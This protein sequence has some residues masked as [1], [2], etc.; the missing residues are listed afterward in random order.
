MKNPFKLD[1]RNVRTVH[2]V[3]SLMHSVTTLMLVVIF[4][5]RHNVSGQA[6]E[7][8]WDI[9]LLMM[10]NGFVV[11]GAFLYYGG[12]PF[13]K[14]QL[15]LIVIAYIGFVLVMFIF[16]C[17]VQFVQKNHPFSFNA[18]FDDMPVIMIICGLFTGVFF[19]FAYFGQRKIDIDLE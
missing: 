15:K 17:L 8:I 10:V 18:V 6:F 5:C 2:I 14:I 7:E 9:G 11:L 3:Q 1:E 19:L 12:I 16:K 13:D 4:F